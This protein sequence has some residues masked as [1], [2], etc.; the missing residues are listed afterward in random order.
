GARRVA[1]TEAE[2]DG[3]HKVAAWQSRAGARVELLDG[4]RAQSVEPALAEDVLGALH[5]P[6]E[7]TIDPPRLLRALSIATVRAGV[8]MR[9]GTTV[10][11]LL[12][13]KNRCSG[14]KL[15]DGDMHADAIVLAAGSWSGLI[16][17]VDVRPVRGQ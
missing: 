7:A 5:C 10:R 3:F 1:S 13:E 15:E 4:H 12:M 11:S 2:L 6:D 17:S 9:S 16:S 8:K 14:V